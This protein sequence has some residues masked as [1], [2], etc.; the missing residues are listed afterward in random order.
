MNNNNFFFRKYLAMKSY[1]REK[2]FINK[3][4][5]INYYKSFF[6]IGVLFIL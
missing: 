5:L 2:F 6:D 1:I 4:S 3:N